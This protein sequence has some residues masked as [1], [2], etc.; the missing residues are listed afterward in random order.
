MLSDKITSVFP[1][2]KEDK[3]AIKEKKHS[4]Y[5]KIFTHHYKIMFYIFKKNI[6]IN[7]FKEMK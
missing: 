2:F 4:R 3:V 7:T 6:S 1:F 5:L